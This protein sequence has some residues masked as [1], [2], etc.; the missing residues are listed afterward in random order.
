MTNGFPDKNGFDRD[1]NAIQ[2]SSNSQTAT[3]M[4]NF[5]HIIMKAC[6]LM[7]DC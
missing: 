6:M 5:R 2:F 4:D 7:K 1:F 3:D